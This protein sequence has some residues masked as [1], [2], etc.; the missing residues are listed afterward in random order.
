[1]YQGKIWEDLCHNLTYI[2]CDLLVSGSVG[3]TLLTVELADGEEGIIA[4]EGVLV[5]LG[6]AI[7]LRILDIVLVSVSSSVSSARSE[8]TLLRSVSSFLYSAEEVVVRR[9]DYINLKQM[10]QLMASYKDLCQ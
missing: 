1:M 10:P 2:I 5:M 4:A 9:I 8:S 7:V 3:I 6:R